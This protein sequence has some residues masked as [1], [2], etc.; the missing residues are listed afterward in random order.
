MVARFLELQ[1]DDLAGGLVFR[2]Y[3]SLHK[4]ADHSKSGMPLSEEYRVFILD[5]RPIF[6]CN[7]WEEGEYDSQ[8]PDLSQFAD[9]M[10]KVP[11]R[12]F[13]MDIART[14]D[15][16][17]IIVELGDGQVSGLQTAKPADFYAALVRACAGMN[18]GR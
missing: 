17:W 11:N 4:L 18:G 2:E 5:G 12:F 6:T 13:T 7:Y 9:V 10:K 3:V 1:D 8:P 14:A 16:R 15:G